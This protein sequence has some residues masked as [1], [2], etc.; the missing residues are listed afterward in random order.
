MSDATVSDGR[1]VTIHYVLRDASGAELHSTRG[2]EPLSYTHGTGEIVD[3]LERALDGQQE[4]DS[5][6]V[7]LPPEDAFGAHDPDK[8]VEVPAEDL[9]FDAEVGTL[10]RAEMPDGSAH[11]FSVT[12]VGEATVTLDG[13]HPLAGQTVQF[14][15]EIVEVA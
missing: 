8:V 4:G 13:N 12:E 5:V 14:E 6:D 10:I 2:D 1:K 15:A 3:G 9:G 11:H 7:T